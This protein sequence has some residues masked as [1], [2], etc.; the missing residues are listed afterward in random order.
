[1]LAAELAP[2]YAKHDS[3]PI[4]SLDHLHRR[5]DIFAEPTT[6]G[7]CDASRRVWNNSDSTDLKQ[8][9]LVERL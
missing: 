6:P 7:L 3:V 2:N 9:K 4:L 8:A 1:M 5:S